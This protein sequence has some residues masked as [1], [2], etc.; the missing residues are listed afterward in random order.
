MI[1]DLSHTQSRNVR[2]LN[3]PFNESDAK[4]NRSVKKFMID[5]AFP[6]LRFSCLVKPLKE[7]NFCQGPH[8]HKLSS[9]RG[10]K[11]QF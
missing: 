5:V 4:T 8:F 7:G 3:S 9:Q 1:P 11:F 6:R 10:H 2:I